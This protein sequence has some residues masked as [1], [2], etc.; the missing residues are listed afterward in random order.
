MLASWGLIVPSKLW[1][2]RSGDSFTR[3]LCLG[4][5]G[6]GVG[7]L[8]AMLPKYL[9]IGNDALFRG[10][11]HSDPYVLGRVAVSDGS[12]FPT[13]ACFMIFFA[14]L[15]SVRRWW[16]QVDSFRTS[17]FRV[18]SALFTL[19]VGVVITG[20]LQQFSFPDS[21]GATWAL[22]ISAVVQLSAGWTPAEDRRLE[23]VKEPKPAT[24]PKTQ[25]VAA[26]NIAGR[27]ATLNNA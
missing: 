19:L 21:L 26:P 11:Q 6:L 5:V 1:E 4:S 9:L 14:A 18:S 25:D 24:P 12:G 23:P 17:R 8:A 16:W 2:G 27:E 22:A 7:F 13:I 10:A 20:V 3:R 15:F